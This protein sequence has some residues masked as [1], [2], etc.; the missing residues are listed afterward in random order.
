MLYAVRGAGQS[1][2]LAFLSLPQWCYPA[3]DGSLDIAHGTPLQK[4]QAPVDDATLA[5]LGKHI[6]LN[7]PDGSPWNSPL[8]TLERVEA[9][10]VKLR[11]GWSEYYQYLSTCGRLEFETRRAILRGGRTPFRDQKF[12]APDMLIAAALEAQAVGICACVVY[13]DKAAV[14]QVLLQ[15]RQENVATYPGT[16]AVVPMFGCQPLQH[17]PPHGVSIKHDLLR[18]FG[19]ELFSVPELIYPTTHLRYDWFYGLPQIKD[20]LAL[21]RERKLKLIPL[22]F[23]FDGLNG[24]LDIALLCLFES[25][26][27]FESY[28]TA[29]RGNWEIRNIG[30][31]DIFSPEVDQIISGDR[32]HPGSAFTIDLARNYLKEE[33]L[34]IARFVTPLTCE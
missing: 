34:W 17:D 24:E 1:K 30:T 19:E 32:C 10:P 26:E 20:L 11:V 9:D 15:R 27:F 6:S 28:G 25:E 23:G 5:E 18:E 13:Q 2:P 21:E 7:R 14:Y 16:Y 33:L 3:L 22:G 31:A 4:S 12:A 8:I 29:M